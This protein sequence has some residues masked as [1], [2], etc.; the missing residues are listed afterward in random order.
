M[1]TSAET[2]QASDAAS[3]CSV[4]VT[5][6][7]GFIGSALV[8]RLRARGDTVI[9]LSRQPAHTEKRL[10][11]RSVADPQ[12]I[13]EPVDAIVHLAGANVMALPWTSARK[14]VL[15]GSR[16][17][18]A[19]AL[20]AWQQARPHQAQSWVQ[21]SA[22]G[23]Y[24]TQSSSA[25]T[26]TAPSGS[27]FAAELCQAI[28]AQSA[29]AAALGARVV[30]LRFGLVLGAKGGVYPMLRLATK[31]GGGSTV[32]SGQQRVAWIHIEDAVGLIL[33]S[34]DQPKWHGAI[35]AVAPESPSY[36]AFA[37]ALAQSVQRPSWLRVPALLLKLALGAR[38]PL[39]L[40][41]AQILPDKAQALGYTFQY[42]QL[43]EALADLA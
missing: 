32:G 36:Q 30:N 20:L 21:A 25:L 10:G 8:A 2:P 15:R 31:L 16:L 26:E 1:S 6:A 5:G 42:P 11:V 40:E 38:A 13:A 35:N 22:V 33:H 3:A 24:P 27:G 12:D 9:A 34:L 7:S 41:G 29:R 39:L 14:A 37:G 28:E 23:F 17:G 19:E 4:L 43:Q 18:I